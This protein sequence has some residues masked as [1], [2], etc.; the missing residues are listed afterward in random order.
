MNDVRSNATVA[1]PR[2]GGVGLALIGLLLCLWAPLA[3][4]KSWKEVSGACCRDAQRI[5]IYLGKATTAPLP[6]AAADVVVSNPKIVEVVL[7]TATQPVLFGMRL[8]Q[9][10]ILFFDEK[11]KQIRALDVRVEYD[12]TL[13]NQTIRSQFPGSR[14]VAKSVLGEI[15]LEGVVQNSHAAKGIVDLAQRFVAAARASR[16]AD[17][18]AKAV[19]KAATGVVSRIAVANEEQVHLRVRV[20]EVNRTVL[21]RLGVDWNAGLQSATL[22]STL[23]LRDAALS[24]FLAAKGT[25]IALGPEVLSSFLKALEQHSLVATLAEPSLTAVSGE[26]A[27]FLAGGEYPVPISGTDGTVTIEYKKFGVGLDFTPVL[28][29]DGRISLKVKTEVSDLTTNGAITV[30]TVQVQALTVRRAESTVELP[31]G[32][33][34]MIAGLIKQSTRRLSAGL[35]GLRSLP[36]I[37]QFF[38]NEEGTIDETELVVLVTPYVVRPSAPKRFAAPTDGFKP[39]SDVDMYLFGRLHAV[40]GAGPED[41]A[42]VRAQTKKMPTPLGFIME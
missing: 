19:D 5:T 27:S 26:T 33:T 2:K 34:I 32:G 29:D 25:Q 7:R 11:S 39:A 24:G 35:P 15:I 4:A 30:G 18:A 21:K 13:L 14:V 41:A 17:G 22:S 16:S 42:R 9:A 23:V 20:A 36:V 38:R 10:N 31:S 40:Y 8:G 12:V 6:K 37:G 3:L 1:A 28:L